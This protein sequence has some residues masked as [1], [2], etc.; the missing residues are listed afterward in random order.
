MGQKSEEESVTVCVIAPETDI[1]LIESDLGQKVHCCRLVGYKWT[2][3]VTDTNPMN[4]GRDA[5]KELLKPEVKQ[6]FLALPTNSF[7]SE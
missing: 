4:Q 1:E 7:V 2:G 3:N 6:N 5:S